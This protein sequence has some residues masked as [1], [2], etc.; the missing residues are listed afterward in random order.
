ALLRRWFRRFAPV[1]ASAARV[2]Y[3]NDRTPLGEKLPAAVGLLVRQINV[4]DLLNAALLSLAAGVSGALLVGW[5]RLRGLFGRRPR[6]PGSEKGLY[7]RYAAAA[8]RATDMTPVVAPAAQG[9]EARLAPLA[10]GTARASHIHVLW[11]RNLAEKDDVVKQGLWHVC[12]A[13]V[14]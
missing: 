9:W 6:Q 12:P 5:D 3:R 14:Y 11:P 4:L 8:R 2:V 1:L 13:H 7:G 10:Y